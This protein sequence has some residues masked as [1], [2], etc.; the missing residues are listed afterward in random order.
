MTTYI[1]LKTVLFKNF[2]HAQPF[3]YSANGI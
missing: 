2:T 1:D 3:V